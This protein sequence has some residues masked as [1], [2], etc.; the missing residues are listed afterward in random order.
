MNTGVDCHFLFQGII[1]TQGLNLHLL[2]WQI[3]NLPKVFSETPEKPRN[4]V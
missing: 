3:Q 1:P 2:Y 4:Q